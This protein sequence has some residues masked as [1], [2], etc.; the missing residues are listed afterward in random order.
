MKLRLMA[1]LAVL[2]FLFNRCDNEEFLEQPITEDLTI[3]GEINASIEIQEG[4]DFSHESARTSFFNETFENR[5]KSSYAGAAVSLNSGS[6]YMSDALIGTLSSDRKLGSRSSR[7]RNS[8]YIIMQFDMDNGAS[9][10]R[11]SHARFGND[12]PSSWRL[13]ASYN[14]GNSW[15]YVGSAVTTSSSSLRTIIYNVNESSSVRYGLYKTGGG[16][17]RINYDNFEITTS[18]GGSSATRDSN[19]T[20][21]N[22]SDASTSQSNNYL[23]SRNEY[24]YSYD[25]SRGRINWV[26]WH[27]STAWLGSASRQ[28]DFR[29]DA[30]LPS[31]FYRANSSSYSGSG[32][33]R[34][35]ICPSAD[36]TYS[37]SANSSTFYMSNMGPQAPNNNRQ[38]W[39][40]FEEY[41]RDV[42]RDGNEIHIVAGVIGQGG[43]GNNGFASTIA[44]G[45][46]DVPSS[47]W[48]VA[49]ILPN[50]SNDVI[51]VTSSTRVI[52]VNMP[53][54][55]SI[56]TTNWGIYRTSV[57]QIENVTGLDL[58]ENIS[59]SIES[60]IESRVDN[61]PI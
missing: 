4:T 20:F 54:T 2:L 38:T 27:L 34:G 55:Q 40:L 10:V 29:T 51:R 41:L 39:R 31:S 47:F 36:R 48:K 22:P 11:V 45:K 57:N 18:S 19:L 21:G 1:L 42:A 16:S 56:N 7:V 53:N 33:D 58:F 35:H 50:G 59:N 49:L 52:A 25:N 5:S 6:Y 3:L 24:A 14:G 23:I 44:S 12:S 30:A 8:G 15:Y 9:T 61:R 28:N 37:T 17:N 46:I 43:D 13:I 60:I 26:S 32:F